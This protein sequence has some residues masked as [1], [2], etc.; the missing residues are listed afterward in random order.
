M[1]SIKYIPLFLSFNYALGAVF[2]RRTATDPPVEQQ[3][4]TNA[5]I[6]ALPSYDPVRVATIHYEYTGSS[7][8]VPQVQAELSAMQFIFQQYGFSVTDLAIPL[9][10]SSDAQ[11]FLETEIAS[12][13]DGLSDSGSL[14]ILIY[15]GHGSPGGLWSINTGT[16][17]NPII[18]QVDWGS[19]DANI[20]TPTGVDT[21]QIIDTCFAGS[22][23]AASN[24]I[25]PASFKGRAGFSVIASASASSTA[26]AN[27]LAFTKAV[28]NTLAPADGALPANFTPSSL[29]NALPVVGQTYAKITLDQVEVDAMISGSYRPQFYELGTTIGVPGTAPNTHKIGY[30]S[31]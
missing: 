19:I 30:L 27:Q 15:G 8:E 31:C 24:D 13:Y 2:I 10:S 23:V 17:T 1:R 22:F 29:F 3:P 12:L 28:I 25:D 20:I 11:A 9:S 5:A 21:F 4:L 14:V 18:I 7:A 6:E 16:F 26:G